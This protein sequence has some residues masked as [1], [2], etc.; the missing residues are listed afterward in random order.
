MTAMLNM[1]RLSP[2][3]IV[4]VNSSV[5]FYENLNDEWAY[6]HLKIWS[7]QAIWSRLNLSPIYPQCVSLPMDKVLSAIATDLF[8][9]CFIC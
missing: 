4:E 7:Y 1:C 6:I 2:T 5:D 9:K 8:P 3:Y